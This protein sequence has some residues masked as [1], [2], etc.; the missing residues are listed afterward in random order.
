[1]LSHHAYAVLTQRVLGQ[2]SFVELLIQKRDPNHFILTRCTNGL[3]GYDLNYQR[4]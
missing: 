3:T 2:F 4:K 1:M